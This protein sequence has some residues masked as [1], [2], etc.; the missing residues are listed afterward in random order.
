MDIRGAEAME[1]TDSTRRATELRRYTEVDRPTDFDFSAA[2]ADP[3]AVYRPRP[4][5]ECTLRVPPWTPSTVRI[6]TRQSA[7]RTLNAQRRVLKAHSFLPQGDHRIDARR[8][9]S[10]ARAITRRSRLRTHASLPAKA[11]SHESPRRIAWLPPLG[12]SRE[13]VATTHSADARHQPRGGR[14]A[15]GAARVAGSRAVGR[16]TG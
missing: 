12:G 3:R 15:R 4:A 10:T 13:S 8:A 1:A 6:R 14:S 7:D 2:S 16:A 5:S 9:R 11:G